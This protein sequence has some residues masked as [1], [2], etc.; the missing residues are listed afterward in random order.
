LLR[1]LSG[2]ITGI[3]PLPDIGPDIHYQA[4]GLVGY[5]A[6][7]VSG[8]SL[9]SITVVIPEQ[10]MKEKIQGKAWANPGSMGLNPGFYL[11]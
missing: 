4:S 10:F 8:P 2:R 5:P 11:T 6:K 7:T 1:Q 3:R 9:F